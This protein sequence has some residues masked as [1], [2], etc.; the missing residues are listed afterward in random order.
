MGRVRQGRD[1][2]FRKQ[3]LSFG[4][5]WGTRWKIL[6]QARVVGTH[7][8]EFRCGVTRSVTRTGNTGQGQICRVPKWNNR[9]E[10]WN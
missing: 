5:G 9:G 10:D 7:G 2:E 3:K 1:A 8:S 4:E 6:E